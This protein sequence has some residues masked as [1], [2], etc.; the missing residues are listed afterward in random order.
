MVGFQVRRCWIALPLSLW[1]ENTTL[2]LTHSTHTL[3][4]E[5]YWIQPLY[6]CCALSRLRTYHANN[7]TRSILNTA[8][9]CTALYREHAFTMHTIVTEA[10]W[11]QPLYIFCV[12]SRLRTYDGKRGR[13]ISTVFLLDY[14]PLGPMVTLCM[15]N[16]A[17]IFKLPP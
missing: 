17:S 16:T 6:I 10:Y 2:L 12:L 1:W 9:T 8:S 14:P 5:A 4:T 7:H 15:L 13:L 11:I 3:V